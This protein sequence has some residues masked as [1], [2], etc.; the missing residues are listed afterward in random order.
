MIQIFVILLLV[1]LVALF[2]LASI[3]QSYATA[4]QAQAAIEASRAAQIASAGNLVAI[5]TM[6]MLAVAFLAAVVVIAWLVLR[7]KAQPKRHWARTSSGGWDGLDLLSK[8]Q[9]QANALIP[10]LMTQLLYEM[11]QRQQHESEQFWMSD[12]AMNDTM[13]E[14]PSFL[15]NTWDM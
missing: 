13:N 5:V 4:K 2:G 11:T 6:A 7:A 8:S 15:D 14:V 3:S 1:T 9:P 10:A 12:P